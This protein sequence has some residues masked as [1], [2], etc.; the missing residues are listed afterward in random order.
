MVELKKIKIKKGGNKVVNRL[1]PRLG[2]S[3]EVT[4][5]GSTKTYSFGEGLDSM[6][7]FLIR[8]A[9]S[10]IRREF[11]AGQREHYHKHGIDKV[12]TRLKENRQRF[13]KA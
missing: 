10:L 4:V 12:H 6:F 5:S 9:P 11:W 13:A 8:S 1:F 3:P 2:S 7:R